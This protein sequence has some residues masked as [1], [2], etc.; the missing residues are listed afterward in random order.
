M[1]AGW[2]GLW[3]LV[4]VAALLLEK[5]ETN[6]PFYTL[7]FGVVLGLIAS[8]IVSVCVLCLGLYHS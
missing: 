4:P 6:I 1:A 8:A 2:F 7:A 5:F 3:V